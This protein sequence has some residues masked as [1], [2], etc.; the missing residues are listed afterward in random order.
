[1]NRLTD[2]GSESRSMGQAVVFSQDLKVVNAHKDIVPP[3]GMLDQ[4]VLCINERQ[5]MVR[6]KT[7]YEPPNSSAIVLE[8]PTT[9]LFKRWAE[10]RLIFVEVCLIVSQAHHE[11]FLL[12]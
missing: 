10:I 6:S 8:N 2:N 1:M 7:M 11:L 3:M 12:I 4:D 9:D 5:V